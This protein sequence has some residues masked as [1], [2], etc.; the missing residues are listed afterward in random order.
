MTTKFISADLC[1]GNNPKQFP[2]AISRNKADLKVLVLPKNK[3]EFSKTFELPPTTRAADKFLRSPDFKLLTQTQ[4]ESEQANA[5]QSTVLRKFN[6][7][8]A[9][10]QRNFRLMLANKKK[11]KAKEASALKIQNWWRKVAARKKHEEEAKQA[12]AQLI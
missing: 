6:L 10:V 7:N 8:A 11:A 1:L 5:A 2:A 3:I 4:A 9:V 12:S